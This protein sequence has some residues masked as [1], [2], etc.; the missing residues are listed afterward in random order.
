[1]KIT[2][3][4]SWHRILPL[5]SES[6][7]EPRMLPSGAFIGKSIPSFE[8]QNDERS[9]SVALFKTEGLYV[10]VETGRKITG[11]IDEDNPALN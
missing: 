8:G 11:K 3:Y 9:I 6:H 7:I 2:D 4:I 5:P 10:V 1:M